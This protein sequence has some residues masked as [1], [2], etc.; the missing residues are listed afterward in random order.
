[1]NKNLLKLITDLVEFKTVY[2]NYKEFD[3]CIAYIKNYYKNSDLYIKEYEFNNSKSLVIS[4]SKSKKLDVIFSGHIDVVPA[5]NTLFELKKDGDLLFGRGVSDMKGQV[6]IMMQLIHELSA[7]KTNKK[8]ALFLTSDEERGGFDGTNKL[9][10]E[11]SYSCDVAIVP[12]GGFN[13]SLVDESKGVLQLNV[14]VRGIESHASEL[15]LGDNAILN[16]FEVVKEIENKYPNPKNIF[17]WKTSCN[18]A[19][20]EGGDSFNKVPSCSSLYFDIRHIYLDKK[21]DIINYIKSLD[22]VLDV[23]VVAQ[24]NAFNLDLSNMYVKKYIDICQ[25]I[26]NKDIDIIK[27]QAASD[28][29]FFSEKNIPCLIM[30]PVG[31]NIHSNDEHVSLK[32]LEKLKKI[33]KIYLENL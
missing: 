24:G 3:N 4:N 31:G 28:G 1:M 5:N 26:L 11:L 19:K 17:D 16:S 27:Y 15:W 21:E 14:T 2:S 12:D 30:N 10:N 7:N 32:S 23:E 33:Y 13:F 6:A 20:I 25:I 8:I 9:L 29:R 18:V 22:N